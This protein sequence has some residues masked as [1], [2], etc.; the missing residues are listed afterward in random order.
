MPD[1]TMKRPRPALLDAEGMKALVE[2]YPKP[3]PRAVAKDI[4]RIDPHMRGFIERAPFC[5]LASCD[6]D[7]RVDVGPR[8]D[9]PGSFKVIDEGMIAI[10]DRPGNN[11]LDALHNFTTHARAGAIF[12]I[13]GIDE[14]VRVNGRVALSTDPDLLASMAV[15]GK[16]PLCAIVIEVEE[17]FMHCAK[18]FKR[19][20]LWSD[21][22]RLP[23]EAVASIA[24]V[25][26]DQLGET[27]EQIAAAEQRTERA[28]RD[29]LWAPIS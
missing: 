25:I 21:E 22:Y 29:G 15:D 28:Y 27:R 24:R 18:A 5:C 12:M 26:G 3:M 13:P 8:G 9:P 7:G 4:G 1:T 17:A 2:Q 11:R 6:I 10:A 19:S 23:R 20:K 16:A 14:T